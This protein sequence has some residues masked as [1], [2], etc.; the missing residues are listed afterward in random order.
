VNEAGVAEP[1]FGNRFAAERNM[2]QRTVGHFR[3]V[4]CAGKWR[5][6][7]IFGKSPKRREGRN[8]ARDVRVNQTASRSDNAYNTQG[9]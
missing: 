1:A 3:S 7:H 5:N 8:L 6:G 4:R 9:P 2:R